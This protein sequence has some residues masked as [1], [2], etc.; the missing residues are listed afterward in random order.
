MVPSW[1]EMVSELQPPCLHSREAGRDKGRTVNALPFQASPQRADQ[2]LQNRPTF[3]HVGSYLQQRLGS[4]VVF[5]LAR[6]VFQVSVLKKAETSCVLFSSGHSAGH[7]GS[8]F[9]GQGSN[10]CPLLQKHGAL[11]TG[12]TG[13]PW[14]FLLGG[15]QQLTASLNLSLCVCIQYA[16]EAISN[17]LWKE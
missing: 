7:M 11:T 12:L 15:T 6:H 10:P 1:S 13:K 5:F 17:S 3:S 16:L 14:D 9:P 2:P 8:Q 4:V